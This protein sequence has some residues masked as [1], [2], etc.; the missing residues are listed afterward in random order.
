MCRLEVSRFPWEHWNDATRVNWVN[1][2]V[3]WF[4]QNYDRR[5]R[6]EM[7]KQTMKYLLDHVF[8]ILNN[9]LPG[10][11]YRK[12]VMNLGRALKDVIAEHSLRVFP[13][14]HRIVHLLERGLQS[15]HSHMFVLPK[16]KEKNL[17]DRPEYSALLL[18][19]KFHQAGEYEEAIKILR[20]S[21]ILWGCSL[22]QYIRG[23]SERKLVL[24]S[25][26]HAN[27]DAG[28]RL[29]KQGEC[30]CPF[31]KIAI[32]DSELLKAVIYR[33]KAVVFRKQENFKE[34]AEFYEKAEKIIDNVWKEK[35]NNSSKTVN[36]NGSKYSADTIMVEH[37]GG[38]KTE[39][40]A[41]V[42]ADVHFSHGY[43]WYQK[44]EYNK[45]KDL[46]Q[47]AI[48]ALE[49][50]GESWDS[51]YTRLAIVKF[52]EG[53]YNEAQ[54]LFAK[55]RLLCE[56]TMAENR[57]AALSL[58]LCDLGSE[59]IRLI[60]N[61]I[62][63]RNYEPILKLQEAINENPKLALG[64]LECHRNDA[65]Y[66]LD[67]ILS[68]E[69]EEAENLVKK[70]IEKIEKEINHITIFSYKYDIFI[71]YAS[72][73]KEDIAS[74][75][76]DALKNRGLS[77]WFDEAKI[78]IGDKLHQKINEGLR[79]SK[80]AIVILSKIYLEKFCPKLE[81]NALLAGNKKIFPVLHGLTCEEVRERD[82]ILGGI[83]AVSSDKGI[84]SIVKEILDQIDVV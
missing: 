20:N 16:V 72:E 73:D 67:A 74:P 17:L 21:N 81:L 46:F 8:E 69:A 15:R 79:Q 59:V 34:A 26:A 2:I 43:Y 55:A 33:A 62:L 31:D 70:F 22:A 35:N 66:I 36:T 9:S 63:Q 83:K 30:N 54:D 41:E 68:K 37:S 82:L 47:K 78:K 53:K 84:D 11:L 51:P 27:L 56:K 28:L 40:I 7:A 48:D 3:E 29:L 76:Y 14:H 58:A 45:A 77:V 60:N 38:D 25:E 52:C 18:A 4:L 71:S 57:E 23:Q 32:C 80:Y 24:Y 12:K 49:Q 19:T 61:H 65:V 39:I 42:M 6:S 13:H 64:P 50:L 10:D 1:E 44:K 75:L 5:P